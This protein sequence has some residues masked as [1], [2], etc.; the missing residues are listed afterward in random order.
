MNYSLLT[1]A[2]L[3]S[4]LTL[5]QNTSDGLIAVNTYKAPQG[6]FAIDNTF[7]TASFNK[8]YE[9]KDYTIG[10]NKE[11]QK[12]QESDNVAS[13]N[14][15]RI[16]LTSTS[17]PVSDVDLTDLNINSYRFGLRLRNLYHNGGNVNTLSGV[18]IGSIIDSFSGSI[19]DKPFALEDSNTILQSNLATRF[20]LKNKN[21]IGLM[22]ENITSYENDLSFSSQ[23][24]INPLEVASQNIG[25]GL[26]FNF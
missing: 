18:G 4:S 6:K 12:D 1:L 10:T 24:G 9:T 8:K 17:S 7:D 11:S 14:K 3:A 5:A 13:N 22:I 21:H 2:L 15:K 26:N 23:N 25:V 19:S 16:N 20:E